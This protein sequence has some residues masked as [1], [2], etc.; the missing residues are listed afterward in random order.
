VV[1]IAN[2]DVSN[3]VA[4]SSQAVLTTQLIKAYN[5]IQTKQGVKIYMNRSM[6]QYLE[7]E[8]RAAVS[9]G[10]QLSYS[11]VDGVSVTS[12]RGIPIRI[13]DSLLETEARVT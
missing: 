4:Q 1:R 6:A 9:T 10:G 5:K 12:F 7:I 8:Q 2:I 13:V 3:M 11:V